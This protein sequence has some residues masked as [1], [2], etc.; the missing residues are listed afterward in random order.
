MNALAIRY[1][2]PFDLFFYIIIFSN[3]HMLLLTSFFLFAPFLQF[4]FFGST[5]FVCGCHLH[6]KLTKMSIIQSSFPVLF[7]TFI[8][9]IP[10]WRINYYCFLIS[11]NGFCIFFLLTIFL[12]LFNFF[13]IYFLPKHHTFYSYSLKFKSN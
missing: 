6:C 10:A 2:N 7:I 13:F 3:E 5:F 11:T 8:I 4:F 12:F 9:I 1:S